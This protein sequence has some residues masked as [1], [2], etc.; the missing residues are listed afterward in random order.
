MELLS[1]DTLQSS[2]T[3][4]LDR[5]NACSACSGGSCPASWQGRPLVSVPGP[6]SYPGPG[7]GD[8]DSSADVVLMMVLSTC[9]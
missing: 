4:L 9:R 7:D 2:I 5:G 8:G 6:A 1:S 3:S